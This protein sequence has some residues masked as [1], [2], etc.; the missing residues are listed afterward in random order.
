MKPNELR[1]YMNLSRLTREALGKPHKTLDRE[2]RFATMT[3][4]YHEDT[5]WSDFFDDTTAY[6]EEKYDVVFPEMT[7]YLDELHN[8]IVKEAQDANANTGKE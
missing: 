8:R 4:N 5:F 2:L 3:Y 7:A 1:N 6:P